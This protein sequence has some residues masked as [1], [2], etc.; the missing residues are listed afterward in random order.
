MK[1][2]RDEFLIIGKTMRVSF[3]RP[4]Y[5]PKLSEKGRFRDHLWIA[6]QPQ[7][8]GLAESGF[9]ATLTDA[10]Q[11]VDLFRVQFEKQ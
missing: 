10:P 1:T 11:A 6:E 4:G 9:A 7:D 2:G 5:R 8:V 3:E